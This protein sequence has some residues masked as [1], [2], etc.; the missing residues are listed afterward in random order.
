[1]AKSGIGPT[2][3][4]P[5]HG[6]GTIRTRTG[7]AFG[8]DIELGSRVLR[9]VVHMAGALVLLYYVLPSD[10]FIV[11]TMQGALLLALTGVLLLEM[12][13]Q[14]GWVELAFIRPSEEGHIGSYAWY[15]IALTASVLLF[16]EPIAV[17]MVLGTAF[18]DPLIGEVRSWKGPLGYPVLPY[19][20][21]ALLALG[22]LI[23]VGGWTIL[24][25]AVAALATAAVA[26]AVEYPKRPWL[27]D[28]LTMTII[29][30][31]FLWGLLLAVPGLPTLGG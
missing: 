10:F 29:P 31:L 19:A 3:P 18:V 16:P 5:L 20:V 7:E 6:D 13:R 23:L 9:R 24:G 12:C 17:V 2:L 8:G 25:A 26:I 1:M 30:G 27:D 15:A 11:I 14:L 21:Y 4:V 28:D 22:A